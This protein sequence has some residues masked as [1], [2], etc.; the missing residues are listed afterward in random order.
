MSQLKLS[1]I[2]PAHDEEDCIEQTVRR[3]YLH[4]C[5]ENIEHEIVVVNDNSSDRTEE[6][7]GD[8]AIDI[9]VLTYVNNCPPH[10]FG[11]AVRRGLEVYS[12]DAVAIYM[13]DASDRPEDLV[14][15]FHTMIE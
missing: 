6:I 15:F 1:V 2:I 5:S 8:L 4:L 7:L 9:P 3:L 10:G 12:G 14:K 11:Y 13:A